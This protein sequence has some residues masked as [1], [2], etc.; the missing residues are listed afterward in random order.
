VGL[1]KSKDRTSI[2]TWFIRNSACR[3]NWQQ[4]KFYWS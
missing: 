3:R 1:S 2:I 4:T